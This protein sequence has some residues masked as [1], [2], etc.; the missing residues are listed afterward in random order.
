MSLGYTGDIIE[1]RLAIYEAHCLFRWLVDMAAGH[2][3]T[4][5]VDEPGKP[6]PSL[7]LFGGRGTQ[8]LPDVGDSIGH[9]GIA[10]TPCGGSV[11][12]RIG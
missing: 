11:P 8:T 4:L 3:G 1:G 6:L 12:G 9:L 2:A 10:F 5:P 7:R